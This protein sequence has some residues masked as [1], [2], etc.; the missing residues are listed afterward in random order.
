M[1]LFYREALVS[2]ISSQSHFPRFGIDSQY[3]LSSPYYG[4]RLTNFFLK[5]DASA[6]DLPTLRRWNLMLRVF[7]SEYLHLQP[8]DFVS[9]F[10]SSEKVQRSGSELVSTICYVYKTLLTLFT[11]SSCDSLVLATSIKQMGQTLPENR[12]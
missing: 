12:N 2:C 9:R 3:A 8:R 4:S 5:D 1:S 7:M 11:V 10:E 6:L